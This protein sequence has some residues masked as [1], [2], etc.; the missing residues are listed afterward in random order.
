[1]FIYNLYI[2]ILYQMQKQTND[3]QEYEPSKVNLF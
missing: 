3:K 1:M 2:K